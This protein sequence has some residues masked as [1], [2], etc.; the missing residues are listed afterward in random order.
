MSSKEKES[1][2]RINQTFHCI[3]NEFDEFDQCGSSDALSIYEKQSGDTT[4]YDG[5]CWSCGQHFSK[6]HVHNSTIASALGIED[7]IVT[8]T[9]S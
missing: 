5:F 6:E 7:G 4:Y 1:G 2:A 8:K 3:A 9:M